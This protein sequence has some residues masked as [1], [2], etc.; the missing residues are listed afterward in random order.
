M[1]EGNTKDHSFMNFAFGVVTVISLL[2][3]AYLLLKDSNAAN[4]T[5]KEQLEEANDRFCSRYE[6]YSLLQIDE[7]Q[8][9]LPQMGNRERE[10]LKRRLNSKVADLIGVNS[11][12]KL[13]ANEWPVG[14]GNHGDLVF[15]DANGIFYVI[16]TKW[17]DYSSEKKD[18]EKK[19]NK[20][21]EQARRYGAVWGSANPGQTVHHFAIINCPNSSK[22]KVLE[23]LLC[24]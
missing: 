2:V 1:L 20:V 7:F 8:V 5:E 9:V 16:E 22:P 18:I 21:K 10:R 23:R 19:M 3:G 4:L 6:W 17:I 14:A 11:D 13:V 24:E 15:E 12:L